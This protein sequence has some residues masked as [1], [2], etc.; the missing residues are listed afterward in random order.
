M[1]NNI[2]EFSKLEKGKSEYNFVES[3][4]AFVMHSA[5]Q[6]L[7]YWFEKERFEVVSE[8]DDKIVVVVDPEKMKQVFENL[9]NNAIKYSAQNKKI[10]GVCTWNILLMY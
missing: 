2:L 4:L 5:L 1:I 7:N 8:L 6:E 3:N 9:L 10:T